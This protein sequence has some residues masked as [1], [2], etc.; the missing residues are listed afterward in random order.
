MGAGRG[1]GGFCFGFWLA[2]VEKWRSSL[3]AF[4][5]TYVMQILL[6]SEAALPSSVM[7]DHEPE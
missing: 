7:I 4:V 2:Y 3:S 1:W 5:I 6:H